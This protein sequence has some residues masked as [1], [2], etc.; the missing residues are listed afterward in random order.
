MFLVAERVLGFLHF[1]ASA[2]YNCRCNNLVKIFSQTLDL[3]L[4]ISL[5][6]N[7]LKYLVTYNI[8]YFVKNKTNLSEQD[9]F[10]IIHR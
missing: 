7:T 6:G 8:Q 1:Y 5:F 9:D 2:T 3:F 4:L 10:I